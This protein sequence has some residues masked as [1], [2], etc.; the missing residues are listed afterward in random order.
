MEMNLIGNIIVTEDAFWTGLSNEISL[1]T[2]NSPYFQ[3]SELWPQMFMQCMLQTAVNDVA[4]L[5]EALSIKY[6]H[7]HVPFW[8]TFTFLDMSTKSNSSADAFSM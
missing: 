2:S 5:R 8:S 4:S 3:T 7:P 1:I 6:F